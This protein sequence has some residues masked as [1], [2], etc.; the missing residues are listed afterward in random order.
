MNIF[1]KLVIMSLLFVM[2]PS[3]IISVVSVAQLSKTTEDHTI[4]YMSNNANNKLKL[5]KNIIDSVT[6]KAYV[7]SSDG[8]VKMILSDYMQNR[9]LSDSD[10]DTMHQYLKAFYDKDSG[11]FDGMFFTDQNGVVVADAQEGETVGID[12]GERSYFSQVREKGEGAISEVV[13]SQ[14]TG[15]PSIV[16]AQPVMTEENVFVGILAMVIDFSSLTDSIIQ[17]DTNEKYNYVIIDNAGLIIAHENTDYVNQLNFSTEDKSTKAFFDKMM[18]DPTSYGIYNLKGVSKIM[19]YTKYEEMNWYIGCALSMEEYDK[20]INHLK[21]I[22]ATIFGICVVITAIFVFLFS[23]SFANPI[24]RLSGVAEAIAAGDLTQAV[25]SVRTKD[26]IGKLAEA[27]GNMTHKLRDFISKV[28]EMSANTAASSEEMM[29]SS[30]E[31]NQVSE[32]IAVA[33]NELAKG[34]AEQAESTET[35]NYKIIDVVSG[36]NEIGHEMAQSEDLA[37]TAKNTVAVGKNSVQYQ[38]V[39]MNE[40]KEIKEMTGIVANAIISLAE[41]SKEIEE[42]LTV[43]KGISEQTNLLSLNAA[44]EAARAG[45]QGRGFAVVAGEIGK[46]AEQSGLS[47]NK[48]DQI[49]KEVQNGVNNAV[50]EIE[51]AQEV[52]NEQETAL[53]DTVNAFQRIEEVVAAINAN[54]IKVTEVSKAL[55]LKAKEAGEAISDI[56]SISEENASGTEEVA[57]STQEQ[58][59]VIK[60]IA[61]ASKSLS[62]MAADLQK[63]IEVF[64]I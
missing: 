19:A 60:Q 57:A 15:K 25:P 11:L 38:T 20:P 48:I 44:I 23:R 52:V 37:V 36:L 46:L 45:E 3:T 59:A 27:F 7:I 28:S 49:I 56:A 31:V 50:T 63:S 18:S 53:T 9:T 54:I 58:S 5:M 51:K 13:V 24:K 12:I 34:A 29:A 16:I 35:S 26:E 62:G 14:A 2:I 1:K 4:S 10:R 22:V 41:R 40:N 42:I 30:D 43:I 8:R 61:E 33:I 6:D 47:V 21:L 17:R 39:K 32:Q 64:R 55:D